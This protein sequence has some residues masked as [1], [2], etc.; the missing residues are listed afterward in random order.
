[1]TPILPSHAKKRRDRSNGTLQAPTDYVARGWFSLQTDE[2]HD[3]TFTP[4]ALVCYLRIFD[5]F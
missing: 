1:M 2:R 3:S 4:S 5:R